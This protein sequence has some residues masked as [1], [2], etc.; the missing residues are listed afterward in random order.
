MIV[1]QCYLSDSMD[2]CVSNPCLN[3]GACT[4]HLL[5]YLCSCPAHLNGTHC[6]MGKYVPASEYIVYVNMLRGWVQIA[7]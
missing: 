1:L 2:E 3:G 7:H 4:D 5:G 6:D